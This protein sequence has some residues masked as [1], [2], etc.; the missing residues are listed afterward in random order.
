MASVLNLWSEELLDHLSDLPGER[1]S[2]WKFSAQPFQGHFPAQNHGVMEA[3]QAQGSGR[4]KGFQVGKGPW[5]CH[6][7]QAHSGGCQESQEQEAGQRREDGGDD[8]HVTTSSPWPCVNGAWGLPCTHSGCSEAAPEP[9]GSHPPPMLI[10][11]AKLSLVHRQPPEP[12]HLSISDGHLCP[13]A[14]T[15]HCSSLHP[16]LTF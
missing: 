9:Q 14:W 13:V 16:D 11:R 15:T 8:D 5:E 7:S 2:G 4:G 10:L 12:T 1:Y 3:F 6:H